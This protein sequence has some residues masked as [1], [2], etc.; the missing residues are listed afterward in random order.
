ME[1]IFRTM[2]ILTFI[3]SGIR[4]FSYL[5][6]GFGLPILQEQYA[7]GQI[8]V[9]EEMKNAMEEML[10]TPQLFY[11]LYGIA[12]AFSLAGAIIMWR[13][14]WLG[15]HIYT[16]AQLVALALPLAFHG[17]LRSDL[18]AV[19]ITA[20]FVVFYFLALRNLH[21]QAAAEAALVQDN[22]GFENVEED[23]DDDDDE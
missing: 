16:V 21:A 11:I 15:F 6:M 5:V 22:D 12:Y 17:A 13:K 1:R 14:R 4:A 23:T 8:P 9:A 10:N 20:A 3:G 18:G 19:M 7:A 2:L